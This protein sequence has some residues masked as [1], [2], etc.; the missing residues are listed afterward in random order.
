MLKGVWAG[1][2]VGVLAGVD[3]F[4]WGFGNRSLSKGGHFGRSES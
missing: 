1:D 4:C 3:F 2:R